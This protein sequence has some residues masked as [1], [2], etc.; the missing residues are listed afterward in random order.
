MKRQIL[1]TDTFQPTSGTLAFT[2]PHYSKWTMLILFN[3]FPA[4]SYSLKYVKEWFVHAIFKL[5]NKLNSLRETDGNVR[6]PFHL[7]ILLY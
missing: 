3:L 2:A 4:E 1:Y 5:P 7:S 6:L